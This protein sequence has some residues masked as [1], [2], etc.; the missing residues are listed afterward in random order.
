MKKITFFIFIFL[1][2]Q[3][4]GQVSQ[5]MKVYESDNAF[6]S[7]LEKDGN[8][9]IYSAGRIGKN[10]IA[11]VGDT[12][13]NEGLV[14]TKMNVSGNQVWRVNN[15]KGSRVTP[16]S[17][18]FDNSGN[19][20]VIGNFYDTLKVG[21][22]VFTASLFNY[23]KFFIAKYN[24]AGNFLWIKVS[25]SSESFIYSAV[26][27]NNQLLL[28]GGFLGTFNYN[29][30]TM[31]SAGMTDI[32]ILKMDTAGNLLSNNRYGGTGEDK[33]EK[34]KI[35]H[36]GN[37]I[38][39]GEYSGTFSIST[40][41]LIAHGFKDCFLMQLDTA[42][43]V[44]WVKTAGGTSED[45]LRGLA[46]DSTNKIFVCGH[47][48]GYSFSFDSNSLTLTNNNNSVGFI[49]EFNTNGSLI[50]AMNIEGRGNVIDLEL[51]NNN[52]VICGKTI[53]SAS[54][55]LD[56]SIPFLQ[57]NYSN[58]GF[59]IAF[60]QNLNATLIGKYSDAGVQSSQRCFK[61]LPVGSESFLIA[62]YCGEDVKMPDTTYH[63]SSA[64][65]VSN[66]LGGSLFIQRINP[67][68]LTVT[69][70]D[71][72]I[73]PILYSA[74]NP[75]KLAMLFNGAAI[76]LNN[77]QVKFGYPKTPTNAYSFAGNAVYLNDTVTVSNSFNNPPA[78]TGNYFVNLNLADKNLMIRS[79]NTLNF[80]SSF[81][82]TI[83]GP[84]AICAGDTV[85]LS[86]SLN[87]QN[88]NWQPAGSI[89]SSN[90][91][92]MT[93]A[94]LVT[95]TYSLSATYNNQCAI[96]T[97]VVSVNNQ[98]LA[99]VSFTNYTSTN[100]SPIQLGYQ[101]YNCSSIN[102]NAFVFIYKNGTLVYST[103][104]ASGTYN[105][106][107]IGDYYV[108]VISG[109]G[110]EI[111][112]D[113][114]SITNIIAPFTTAGTLVTNSSQICNGSSTV[115]RLTNHPQNAIFEWYYNYNI[116]ANAT[117]DSLIA[118]QAGVY[119]VRVYN[120][121]GVYINSNSISVTLI[122]VQSI[123]IYTSSVT[124][125][126][127]GTNVNFYSS[128]SSNG[129]TITYQWLK[130]GSTISGATASFYTT[131]VNGTYTLRI[132]H[133]CG[134]TIS[135]AITL[136]LDNPVVASINASGSTT[137]CAGQSVLLTA[138]PGVDYSYQW[139]LNG[140]DIIDSTNQTITVTAAGSYSCLVINYC[141]SNL[142]NAIVLTVTPALPNQIATNDSL[143][144]CPG[145]SVT[146]NAPFVS[147][148]NY[149]WYRDGLAISGA[150][151]NVYQTSISGTY[152]C[153]FSNTCGVVFS[154]NLVVN[155]FNLSNIINA[156]YGNNLCAG[157]SVYLFA[158]ANT[159]LNF[160]WN[161]NGSSIAGATNNFYYASVPGV[162]SCSFSNSNCGTFNSGNISV[163][164]FQ[165]SSLIITSSQGNIL[166]SGVTADLSAP[167]GIGFTFQWLL[168]NNI[169][170]G[171][172]NDSYSTQNAG[173]YSCIVHSTCI[174]DTTN[175]YLLI[176][177]PAM[178]TVSVALS[179]NDTICTNGTSLL[180][181]TTTNVADYQWQYNGVNINGATNSTYAASA[182]GLFQCTVSN[183][184]NSVTSNAVQLIVIPEPDHFVSF[185]GDS[186]I[187]Q[188]ESIVLSVS[189][190]TAFNYQW[191]FNGQPV[192]GATTFQYVVSLDGN[193]FCNTTTSCGSY[194]SQQ[195]HVTV[196]LLPPVPNFSI[197]GN[198]LSCNSFGYSYQWYFNG[199]PITGAINQNYQATQAGFYSVA[200]VNGSGCSSLSIPQYYSLQ[201]FVPVSSFGYNNNSICAGDCIS[202]SDNST[203]S[204]NYWNWS[205]QGGNPL[206]ST[207]PNPTVCYSQSGN[208]NVQVITGNSYGYD[209]LL[210][211]QFITVNAIPSA[212][213]TQQHDTLMT[214]AGMVQY[215]WY[216][217]GNTIAGATNNYFVAA[218][219]GNYKVFVQGSGG[220]SNTTLNN[221]YFIAK[222][223][224]SFNISNNNV[225]IGDCITLTDGSTNSP[226]SW[227]W[228]LPG[229]SIGST[230]AQ[231]PQVCYNQQGSYTVTLISTN[232]TGSDT[233]TMN[234][235]V[236]VHAP[237]TTPVITING[238]ILTSSPAVSYQWYMNGNLIAG[239]V[240]QQII[241]TVYGNYSVAVADS[242]GCSSQSADFNHTGTND[243]FSTDFQ[244]LISP[245]P[246]DEYFY[247]S[248]NNYSGTENMKL[249]LLNEVGQEI[250]SK[251]IS[252]TY[253]NSNEMMETKN[254]SSGCYWIELKGESLNFAQK[255]IVIH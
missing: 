31:V 65:A 53:V 84:S 203:N 172:T 253:G 142:S 64:S 171:A 239:A 128:Y 2:L 126:C 51:V 144:I 125:G 194:F 193:Y 104:I 238:N 204:P 201:G 88:Y 131:G 138:S 152:S 222:P 68:H 44:N 70:S 212:L 46:I 187:C 205:F 80:C 115:L 26:I 215:Q 168:N 90:G 15:I 40:F 236:I 249:I 141:N 229:S 180:V 176:A 192:A 36:N 49:A 178:P 218:T 6:G 63:H 237:P 228:I 163:N 45:E 14:F 225:C 47:A 246:A 223:F 183:Y 118:Y 231:N 48:L 83:G 199:V 139:R 132:N 130:N 86:G 177:G 159:Q 5:L 182:Q 28:T 227:H 208:Y 181:A 242:F 33:A 248:F 20:Y 213:I 105:A 3:V 136:H 252:L 250:Q 121:C 206:T 32:C 149:L 25:N 54:I 243:L 216:L 198:L 146:F 200:I 164:L 210:L 244:I 16:R 72:V 147:G 160:Q 148:V 34:I 191:Y 162:Y 60:D 71:P 13:K 124:Q 170:S 133:A 74:A 39:C 21:N 235:L 166:C 58:A 109:C 135:N 55:Y 43:N 232:T 202:Y 94:P 233:I 93:S 188:G 29:G 234:N 24:S 255:L 61:I 69:S 67:P 96:A 185:S 175:N 89:I 174:S 91:N 123:N 221:Y 154:N 19:N 22:Q 167:N 18:L 214:D 38:V 78:G 62:G 97:K 217:N 150:N 169:I 116:I 117:L 245:N 66:Y 190:N 184:C 103:S 158:A 99:H 112:S 4:K 134:Y 140:N 23:R 100:C 11:S 110:W 153:R 41:S 77:S 151:A 119:Y 179:G 75:L 107:T 209:T 59:F 207:Q 211:T 113:T 81:Y 87:Y 108:K 173:S 165:L 145:Q 73:M 224:A 35:D 127:V 92:L 106:T 120:Q 137:I 37:S 197:F 95:T 230:N 101:V 111:Y 98:A 12:I 241:I 155:S 114:I 9:F 8:G 50:Q 102:G 251:S 129:G 161:L 85:T 247:I 7:C 220:C 226:T 76:T 189:S 42:M 186:V 82:S 143:N 30:T 1:Q 219:T 157:D 240:F 27:K 10:A 79:E 254:L 56:T 196:N 57:S 17:I 156:P 122:G 195:V 52:P